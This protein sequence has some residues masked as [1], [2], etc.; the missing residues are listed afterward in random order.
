MFWIVLLTCFLL[1]KYYFRQ[2][3]ILWGG[4]G[5]VEKSLMWNVLAMSILH[6]IKQE[7]WMDRWMIGRVIYQQMKSSFLCNS[8]KGLCQIRLSL[9]WT[10]CLGFSTISLDACNYLIL[11]QH[12]ILEHCIPPLDYKLPSLLGLGLTCLP[13]SPIKYSPRFC[14]QV[15]WT[16]SLMCLSEITFIP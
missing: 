13:M 2:I 7:L 14:I 15:Q 12:A 3:C 4:G 9:T 1:S 16:L 10:N 6:I 5:K 8:K 11:T